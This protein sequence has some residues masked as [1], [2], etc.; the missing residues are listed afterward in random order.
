MRKVQVLCRPHTVFIVSL[1]QPPRIDTVC[2]GYKTKLSRDASVVPHCFFPQDYTLP[3]ISNTHA[4]R[5]HGGTNSLTTLTLTLSSRS[6][7]KA[8]LVS[9]RLQDLIANY[10]SRYASQKTSRCAAAFPPCCYYRSWQ[11][12]PLRED[13]FFGRS[14]LARR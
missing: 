14:C 3:V 6:S 4:D 13:F 12:T 11:A 7:N 8:N 5:P 1:T 9:A 10:T 2:V